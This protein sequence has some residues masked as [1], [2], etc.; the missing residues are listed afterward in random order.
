[1]VNKFKDCSIYLVQ[2]SA[3]AFLE[4][5]ECPFVTHLASLAFL[6]AHSMIHVELVFVIAD[7]KRDFSF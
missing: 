4:V 6:Y 5:I 3:H 1:M 7:P 2:Y